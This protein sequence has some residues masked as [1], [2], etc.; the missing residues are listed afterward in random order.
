MS[1]GSLR[2]TWTRISPDV[3]DSARAIASTIRSESSFEKKCRTF[4]ALPASRGA[5]ASGE[6]SPAREAASPP[7]AA[8][9]AKSAEAAKPSPS[10]GT[11]SAG[12][13]CPVAR[14]KQDRQHE[15]EQERPQ[16]AEVQ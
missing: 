13:E 15:E 16:A 7:S 9:A 10:A 14:P 12:A 1:S 5:A 2:V 8:P 11:P 4:I 3:P 6:A